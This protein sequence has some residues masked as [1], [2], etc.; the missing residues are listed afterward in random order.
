MRGA[1]RDQKVGRSCLRLVDRFVR[2]ARSLPQGFLSVLDAADDARILRA[3]REYED[4][5]EYRAATR[6]VLFHCSDT[7]RTIR[8]EQRT[9]LATSSASLPN[10]NF[11][12]P[13]S[14]IG[15]DIAG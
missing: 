2:F 1:W 13:S 11:R 15:S 7:L 5:L 3:D 12:K 10:R 9:C 14:T 8:T 4:T 6:R